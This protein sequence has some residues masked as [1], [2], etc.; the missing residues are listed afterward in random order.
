MVQTASAQPSS[1][2]EAAMYKA[3]KVAD[4]TMSHSSPM[5]CPLALPPVVDLVVIVIRKTAWCCRAVAGEEG[6]WTIC[7]IRDICQ[8]VPK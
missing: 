2:Q 7:L 6:C 1:T 4:I 3:W 8:P 5:T